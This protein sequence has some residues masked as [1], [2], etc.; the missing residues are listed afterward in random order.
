[1]TD[2]KTRR[3]FLSGIGSMSSLAIVGNAAADRRDHSDRSHNQPMGTGSVDNEQ[4][5]PIAAQGKT[6][7]TFV[8]DG[9][10]VIHRRQ[11]ESHD[12]VERYGDPVVVF[13]PKR[14]KR[15]RVPAKVRDGGTMTTQDV[16]VIGTF[17]EHSNAEDKIRQKSGFKVV[18][19]D[20]LNHLPLHHYEKEDLEKRNDEII[21]GER[22][23]PINVAWTADSAQDVQDYYYEEND[24]GDTPPQPNNKRHIVYDGE[25]KS[26]DKR[27][28]KSIAS[29]DEDVAGIPTDSFEQIDIRAYNIDDHYSVIGQAHI[30]PPDHNLDCKYLN[31]GCEP[32][33]FTAARDVAVNNWNEGSSN[34]GYRHSLD[35]GKSYDTFDGKVGI[36]Y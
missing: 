8:P 35:Y 24:W 29:G 22:K 21:K 20:H 19:Q 10:S 25:I 26:H 1:M 11:F 30:D 3:Q 9:D 13:E 7:H 34:W 16:R 15:E 14:F 33:Y 36:M 5:L 12:L 17:A 4:G 23:A 28:Q 31:R 27:I 6:T 32:W 2:R 18:A